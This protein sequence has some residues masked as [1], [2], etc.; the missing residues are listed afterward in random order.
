M[1]KLISRI[2]VFLL[3]CLLLSTAVFADMGPHFYVEVSVEMAE[4]QRPF[5]ATLLSESPGTGPV[6][7]WE[8]PSRTEEELAVMPASTRAAYAMAAYEDPDGYYL[9]NEIFYCKD[10]S[11][12]WGYMPP[13]TFKVLLWFPDTGELVCSESLNRFAF[14]SVFQG[15]LSDGVLKVVPVR[16]VLGH[17]LS[18]LVRLILT[19]VIEVG[20]AFLFGYDFWPVLK[21]NLITQIGLNIALALYVH[22]SGSGGFIFFTIYLMMELFIFLVEWGY[23]HGRLPET[24]PE[25][26]G[27]FRVFL[28]ALLANALSFGAGILLSMIWPLS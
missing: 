1:T 18:F 11:F 25:H 16:N 14:A 3:I 28:Y 21:I 23:Y 24:N 22:S 15:T 17:I 27:K 26:P 10:G 9:L 19:L 20:L 13:D 6:G 12:T 5:Y 7:L 2:F 8:G 4:G